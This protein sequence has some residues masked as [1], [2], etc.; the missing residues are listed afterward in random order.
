M[1]SQDRL[2]MITHEVHPYLGN[3]D[4][5]M[6]EDMHG[7]ASLNGLAPPNLWAYVYLLTPTPRIS[8]TRSMGHGHVLCLPVHH[9][10]LVAR[11]S[12]PQVHINNTQCLCQDTIHTPHIIAMY[13]PHAKMQNRSMLVIV[14]AR[15]GAHDFSGMAYSHGRSSSVKEGWG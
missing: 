1:A 8:S 11:P 10:P 2:L 9:G 15:L 12:Y 13:G 3:C 7:K 4:H 6:Q 14:H 5:L